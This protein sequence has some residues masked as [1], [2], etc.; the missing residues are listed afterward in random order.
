MFTP[1]M[2]LEKGDLRRRDRR[3]LD[4]L[5]QEP[6]TVPQILPKDAAE[7]LAMAKI[8]ADAGIKRIDIN[9]SCP[10]V[11]VMKSGRG[12]ALLNHA[13]AVAQVL[14]VT[15]QMPDVHFSLK[16]RLGNTDAT[17]FRQLM[18]IINNAN[19]CH[20]ALHARTASQQYEQPADEN[21]FAQFHELCR[22]PTVYNGDVE[23]LEQ[24]AQIA[25][26]HPGMHAVMIGRAIVA[27]PHLLVPHLSPDQQMA[28]LRQFYEILASTYQTQLCGDVQWLDKMQAFWK[29]FLPDADR[30]LR[31]KILKTRKPDAFRA[32]TA[33]LLSSYC[34][35]E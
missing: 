3:D 9:M 2:R 1:F 19:L 26:R 6:D 33:D 10:F 29:L 25:E 35:E 15:E 17:D 24:A 11:P 18:P 22:H 31:K 32:Y 13:D 8:I 28:R 30:K 20:V 21:A 23:S 5:K 34:P 27:H 14:S 12:A 4:L 16:I 7:V